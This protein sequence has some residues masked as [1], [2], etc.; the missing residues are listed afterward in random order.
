MFS[1]LMSVFRTELCWREGPA[2][3]PYLYPKCR[4]VE[5]G[6][7]SSI[8]SSTPPSL[9]PTWCPKHR[10]G[11]EPSLVTGLRPPAATLAGPSGRG[12]RYRG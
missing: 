8:P 1:L 4:S 11:H 9:A 6:H 2:G 7:T 5:A 12:C 10:N 3:N